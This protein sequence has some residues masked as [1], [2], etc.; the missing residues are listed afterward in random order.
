MNRSTMSTAIEN[1]YQRNPANVGNFLGDFLRENNLNEP[2][3]IGIVL[4]RYALPLTQAE[5]VALS[6]DIDVLAI[7]DCLGIDIY[8]DVLRFVDHFVST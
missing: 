5:E 2:K 3:D 6:I 1:I 8:A 4:P 7:S